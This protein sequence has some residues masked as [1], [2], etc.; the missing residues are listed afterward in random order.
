MTE[1]IPSTL[2]PTKGE[3]V[4]LITA[5]WESLQIPSWTSDV[6]IDLGKMLHAKKTLKDF[7]PQKFDRLFPHLVVIASHLGAKL[8]SASPGAQAAVPTKEEQAFLIKAL[9]ESLLIPDW[10]RPELEDMGKMIFARR[11]LKDIAKQDEQIFNRLFPILVEIANHLGTRLMTAPPQAPVA[12]QSP[13][14]PS[15][16]PPAVVAPKPQAPAPP[17]EAGPPPP[18]PAQAPQ[19]IVPPPAA[20]PMASPPPPA[21]ASDPQAM[22]DI[23]L[24]ATTPSKP[25]TPGTQAPSSPEPPGTIKLVATTPSK[26]ETPETPETQTPA[27]PE[28]PDAISYKAQQSE[29]PQPKN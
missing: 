19:A 24:V 2:S 16:I 17:P 22:G 28:V 27:T 15:T 20:P 6:L 29:S 23:K 21:P 25:G 18:T 8:L 4:F 10:K 7:P 1:T 26:P 13:A 12:A 9:W 14:P 11:S 3:Q 5:L